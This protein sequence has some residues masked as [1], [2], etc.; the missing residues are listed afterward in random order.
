M[1]NGIYLMPLWCVLNL[2]LLVLLEPQEIHSL[3]EVVDYY[4]TGSTIMHVML[5]CIAEQSVPIQFDEVDCTGTEW[6]LD[7]CR[8]NINHTCDHHEDAGV[9]CIGKQKYNNYPMWCCH[10]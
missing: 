2:A 10:V 9:I 3:K 4:I 8:F 6:D 7:E 5:P 1:I